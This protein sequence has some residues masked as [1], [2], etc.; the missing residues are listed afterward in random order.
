MGLRSFLSQC[1]RTLKLAVKPGK[2]ELWLS[3]K[4]SFLGISI[5]GLIG[6]IIKLLSSVLQQGSIT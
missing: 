3:I 6:F 2:S 1:A 5:I 4:I